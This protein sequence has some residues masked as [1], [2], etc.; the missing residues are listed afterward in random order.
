MRAE[1]L[2]HI[3]LS[4]PNHPKYD[5]F[6]RKIDLQKEFR[7]EQMDKAYKNLIKKEKGLEKQT[8]KILDKDEKRDVFVKAGKKAMKKKSGHEMKHKMKHKK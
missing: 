4:F 8:K 3:D 5:H 6:Y 7:R 2:Y 1:T